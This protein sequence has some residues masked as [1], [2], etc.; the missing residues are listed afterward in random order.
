M[1]T[2]NSLFE[3]FL[4][5]RRYLKHVSPKTITW[6]ETS[7]KSVCATQPPG[8]ASTVIGA[9]DILIPVRLVR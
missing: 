3:Q 2:L 5:E 7:W 6:Y 8:L 1:A 4:R 9:S